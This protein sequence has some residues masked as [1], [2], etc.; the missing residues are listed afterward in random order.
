[1]SDEVVERLDRLIAM[2]ALVNKTA[3]TQASREL[4]ADKVNAALLDAT[5]DDWVAAGE[6]ATKVGADAGVSSRT[7]RTRL[8]ELL[9]AGALRRDGSGPSIRYRSTGL[10]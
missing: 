8:A 3:L 5:E 7:V 2:F 10:I 9:T 6:L 4:R 1:M